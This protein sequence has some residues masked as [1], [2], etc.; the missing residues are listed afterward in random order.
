MTLEPWTLV[1]VFNLVKEVFDVLPSRG[2]HWCLWFWTF[3]PWFFV[4]LDFD[5]R[6]CGFLQHCSLQLLVFTIGGF[7]VTSCCSRFF[8]S[9][10]CKTHISRATILDTVLQFLV[11]FVAVFAI[12]Q[13]P[14]P[15]SL[16]NYMTLENHNKEM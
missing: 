6:F 12:P 8:S 9:F 14:P 3:L 1:T 15:P 4:V 13:C 10:T 11:H 16:Y 2:G 5:G 7:T